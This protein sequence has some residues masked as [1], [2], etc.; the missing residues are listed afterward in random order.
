MT[1]KLILASTS[2]FRKT[3]LE[4]FN[5]SFL[6]ASPNVNE[7]AYDNE[8]AHALVERL[9]IEKS[10]AIKDKFDSGII[11]GSDQVALFKD[12]IL[13]KPHTKDKAIKQLSSFSG[14]KVTFLTG[15]ALYNIE[16]NKVIS[17]VEQYQV[18]FRDL[19]PKQ[20]NT[21]LNIEQPFNCAG[22]FKSEGLGVCLFER[23]IGDDPNSLI[24]LP[25]IALN[26]LLLEWDI[27]ILD[28][29]K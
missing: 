16:T 19:T 12:K 20:I 9:S 25:L 5:I 4:K 27:D 22:S 28:H 3:L 10:K 29:Q 26:R 2:P 24:G 18:Q 1:P 15:L 8:T 11:I 6:V 21:Y 7:T 13:G 23:F 14:Q 17:T